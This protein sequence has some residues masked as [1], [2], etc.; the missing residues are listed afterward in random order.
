MP[1]SKIQTGMFAFVS[2]Q[3]SCLAMPRSQRGGTLHRNCMFDRKISTEWQSP[4][5]LAVVN[6]AADVGNHY[7]SI[8]NFLRS[9]TIASLAAAASP[10]GARITINAAKNSVGCCF[11]STQDVPNKRPR[12][13]PR[14]IQNGS[15]F[16]NAASGGELDPMRL[17]AA[18]TISA[19]TG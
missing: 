2:E 18:S 6:D 1:S 13:K 17:K 14:G 5:A 4:R 15:S 9:A 10:D 12:G 8:G 3:H 16:T 11:D 19:T 7:R